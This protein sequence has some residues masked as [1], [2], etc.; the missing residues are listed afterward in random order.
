MTC[1]NNITEQSPVSLITHNTSDL[2]PG[3]EIQFAVKRQL[4]IMSAQY[5]FP[6]A[7]NSNHLTLTTIMCFHPF[8]SFFFLLSS[9]YDSAADY[10]FSRALIVRLSKA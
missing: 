10:S 9:S 6:K 2:L 1:T 5:Q 7:K 3:L 8:S 4:P